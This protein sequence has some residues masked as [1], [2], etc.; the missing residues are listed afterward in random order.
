[1][2]L[3]SAKDPEL[4]AGSAGGESFV[5]LAVWLYGGGTGDECQHPETTSTA[6]AS[7]KESVSEFITSLSSEHK[8]LEICLPKL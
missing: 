8:K 5:L 1:M 4:L 3:V 2:P 6:G 7:M